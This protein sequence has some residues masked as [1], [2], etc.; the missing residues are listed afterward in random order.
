MEKIKRALEKAKSEHGALSKPQTNRTHEHQGSIVQNVHEIKYTETRTV[1]LAISDLQRNKILVGDTKSHISETYKVLRT[2]VLQKMKA[3]NWSTLAITS[4][5][6]GCG[7]TLTSI[8]LAISLAREVNHTVL[9]VDMDLRRP[10]IHKYFIN[11]DGLGIAD[12]LT[13]DTDLNKILVTP[14]IDRLVLLPGNKSLSNSSEMMSS[15]KMVRLVNELKTRYPNRFVIFD[16]PPLLSCDDMI[17]FS[18]YID[19]VMLVIEEGVTRKEELK[20]SHELLRDGNV[21]GVVMNKS[22]ADPSSM[23]YY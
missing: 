20:R 8:N 13:S 10:N 7:K 21:L 15:P 17:A 4:P 2:H 18:P 19:S 16:M 14:S 22:K 11:G 12:Y 1:E 5:T 9:L 23:G 3:N 6:E